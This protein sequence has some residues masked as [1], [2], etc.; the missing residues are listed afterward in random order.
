MY[1]RIVAAI[2]EVDR[3]HVVI[4]GGAQW[5]S[6]FSVFGAPF[7][8]NA[9]YT[10]HKYWM[11]PVQAQIQQYLDYRDKWKV[12]V[13]LGESGENTAEWVANFRTLLEQN[14][15]G[16]CFWPYKKISAE[17]CVATFEKPQYWDEI[18]V[19]AT[20]RPASVGDQKRITMRPS[21]DHSR[22]ALR[23][24]LQRVRAENCRINQPYVHALGLGAIER[25]YHL[26][27][28]G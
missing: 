3:N 26:M 11:P 5:D 7:D 2:R 22:A 12:P 13:W 14:G 6:N 9:M 28:K 15:V 8:S 19:Y 23:D 4:L 24:L 21:L 10:F 20:G 27:Q 25:R 18:V 17:S 16:W 1:K